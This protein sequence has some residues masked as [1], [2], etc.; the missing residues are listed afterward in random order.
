MYDIHKYTQP[1]KETFSQSQGNIGKIDPIII[2]WSK[3][4]TA[5]F[6]VKGV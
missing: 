4:C 1:E 2:T 6:S 3:N 5:L